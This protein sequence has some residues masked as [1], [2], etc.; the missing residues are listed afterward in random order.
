MPLAA[1][2]EGTLSVVTLVGTVEQE[3]DSQVRA[4]AFPVRVID[5]E[6]VLE[7]FATAG[8]ID[9]LIPA[10]GGEADADDDITFDVPAGVDAPAVRIGDGATIRCGEADGTSFQLVAGTAKQ[11]C[12]IEPDD[13]A[14]AGERVVTVAFTSSDGADVTARSMRYDAA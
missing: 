2:D 14:P 6:A 10:P 4:D 8:P 13:D 7:P 9:F 11:R 1:S 12:T 5:G 3:G